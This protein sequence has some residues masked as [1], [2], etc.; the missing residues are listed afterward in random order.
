MNPSSAL[1]QLKKE[2]SSAK[3]FLILEEIFGNAEK[4]LEFLMKYQAIIEIRQ[5][6]G[7][8]KKELIT[9]W[10]NKLEKSERTLKRLLNQVDREGFA[11]LARQKR[12]DTG[13]LKGCDR[14]LKN[15]G[16]EWESKEIALAYWKDFIEKEYKKL[17]TSSRRISPHQVF[18]QLESHAKNNL[19]L[20]KGEYPSCVFVYKILS[21]KIPEKKPKIRRPCQGP[22]IVIQCYDKYTTGEKTLEKITVD[23]SNL[24]WQIDHTKLDNLLVNIYGERIGCLFLT[25]IIDSYSGCPMGIHL[26]FDSAGSHEVALA[27][28]HAILPKQ[29]GPEY[30]LQ[31]EWETVG[32]PEYIVTDNAKEFHSEHLRHILSQLGIKLRFRAYV[33]QGSRVERPF[34]N[35]K[36][37]FAALLPGYKGGNLNERPHDAEKWACLTFEEYERL[38]IRFIIDHLNIHPHPR[39]EHKT[40][41]MIWHEGLSGSPKIPDIR[42]LDICLLKETKTRN[43]EANGALNVFKEIYQAGWGKDED[44]L[45]KYFK[46]HN[47]L[48]G[49]EGSKVVLRYNP[50]NIVEM[51]V[52]TPEVDGQP[53]QYL[54]RVRMRDKNIEKLTLKELKMIRKKTIEGKDKLD[55]SSLYQERLD[56]I[57]CSNEKVSEQRKKQ[58]KGKPTTALLRR[59]EQDRITRETRSDNIL[60]FPPEGKN[61]QPR[62]AELALTQQNE[63]SYEKIDPVPESEIESS[64]VWFFVSDCEDFQ[65]N[66]GG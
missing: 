2:L 32:L 16:E 13:K 8:N 39:Q 62:N 38:I 15:S 33:E 42:E 14:W 44:G 47:F 7:E 57:N 53:S 40:R 25:S 21:D 5:A 54:G 46:E 4:Q 52:Y 27:L 34:K 26:G 28:R 63:V 49:R 60:R 24:V 1:E 58:R 55:Q 30:K 36:T 48:L 18:V 11:A 19:G 20:K 64:S 59:E 31:K 9:K 10:A 29:Y 37:E 56:L 22:D 43:V 66:D 50:D 17:S 3:D 41:L 61:S 51:L 65:E 12:S 23:R 45:S 6:S 35:F